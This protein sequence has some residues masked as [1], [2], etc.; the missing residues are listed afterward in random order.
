M[1]PTAP[2][3]VAQLL[4]DALPLHLWLALGALAALLAEFLLGPWALLAAGLWVAGCLA[5]ALFLRTWLYGEHPHGDGVLVGRFGGELPDEQ[6]R[7]ESGSPGKG[8]V[9]FITG[10]GVTSCVYSLHCGADLT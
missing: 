10:R 4:R 2:L 7:F 9:V 5:D 8:V 6:G 1:P 3:T